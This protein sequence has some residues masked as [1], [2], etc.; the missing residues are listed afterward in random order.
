MRIEQ[1]KVVDARGKP[2]EWLSDDG[3]C[4]NCGASP[5]RQ[6]ETFSGARVCQECGHERNA[7]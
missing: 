5:K 7:E 4:A 1:G 6:I 2:V 3:S